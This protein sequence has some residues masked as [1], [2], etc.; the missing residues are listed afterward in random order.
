APFLRLALLESGRP[1]ILDGF[2][3]TAVPVRHAVPTVGVLIDDGTSAAL[4][5]SDTAPT[6]A[7]WELANATAHLKAVF[8][9]A[10]FPDAMGEL[11]E[12]AL[13]LTPRLFAAEATKLRRLARLYAVHIKPRYH[14]QIVAE[15]LALK[16]PDLHILEPGQ[17]YTV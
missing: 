16:L 7:L 10:S 8:L 13:H 15:L 9:E 11:A 12:I 1:G 4:F 2:R 5:S 3:I 17:T 6:E 14:E